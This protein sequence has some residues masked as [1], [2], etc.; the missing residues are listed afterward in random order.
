IDGGS[1]IQSF[2]KEDLI[3]EIIIT[4]IPILLGGGSPLFGELHKEMRF[5]HVK[6]EIFLDTRVQDHYKRLR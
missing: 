3:D 6:S 4:T 2:L 5:E 1:T